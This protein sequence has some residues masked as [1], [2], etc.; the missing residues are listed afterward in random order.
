M[1]KNFLS[2]AFQSIGNSPIA[3]KLAMW[4]S[5]P[6][7]LKF[8]LS[9]SKEKERIACPQTKRTFLCFVLQWD[10]IQLK[11][12]DCIVF[13]TSNLKVQIKVNFYFLQ[14]AKPRC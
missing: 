11:Y 4:A 13:C 1:K 3:K 9:L 6:P 10:T 2:Y 5:T 14:F 8:C 7:N 12:K